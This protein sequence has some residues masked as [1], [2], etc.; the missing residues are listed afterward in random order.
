MMQPVHTH[1]LAIDAWRRETSGVPGSTLMLEAGHQCMNALRE[2]PTLS[3]LWHS[4]HTLVWILCG[5]GYNGGDGW[6]MARLLK[7][8]YPHLKLHIL[9]T[10]SLEEL[11]SDSAVHAQW[12]LT[13]H[14]DTDSL[15]V[16]AL[17]TEAQLHTWLKAVE[18]TQAFP[19]VVIDALLGMGSNRPLSG[20]FA[21]LAQWLY[22]QKTS[23]RAMTI[24]SIDIPSGLLPTVTTLPSSPESHLHAD[25][26]LAIGAYALVHIDGT[27]R[28]LCGDILPIPLSGMPPHELFP[29]IAYGITAHDVQMARQ[30]QRPEAT[31]HKYQRGK[32]CVIGGCL[33]YPHA[34]WLS[35]ITSVMAGAGMVWVAHGHNMLY[36][37][38]ETS[39]QAHPCTVTPL[40]PELTSILPLNV[41]YPNTLAS[42]STSSLSQTTHFNQNLF[43][44]VSQ[45]FETLTPEICV[46]GPGMGRHPDTLKAF[47][48]WLIVLLQTHPQLVAVLDADALYALGYGLH[49]TRHGSSFLSEDA[50]APLFSRCILTPHAGEAHQLL[51]WLNPSALESDTH[52]PRTPTALIQGT[53]TFETLY[54]L[55]HLAP[56]TILLKGSTTWV[57]QQ[58][59]IPLAV[60]YGTPKLA[61]GGSGDKLAGYIAGFLKRSLSLSEACWLAAYELAH[62]THTL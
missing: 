38:G 34:P 44:G 53:Q 32:V 4:P 14:Q 24:I 2:H 9:S 47:L 7:Q 61:Q 40:S 55:G 48:P 5:G 12:C 42:S 46:I 49:H 22:Q 43:E 60:P 19:A 8:A 27:T 29:P 17:Q 62:P 31:C 35:A 52:T 11:P 30:R 57:Y 23:R 54:A 51:S 36:P 59:T 13:Q 25:I 1:H 26:T 58:D 10:H 3:A 15:Q 37:Q 33:N 56:W 50:R 18:L 45:I 28:H 21:Q 39:L 41:P 16:H 20:V 6:V